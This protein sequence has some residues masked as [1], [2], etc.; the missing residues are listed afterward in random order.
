MRITSVRTAV[1]EA[2]YDWT[3][4][5]IEADSGLAGLGECFFAPGLTSII[6][7]LR[8]VL[9]GQDPRHVEPLVRRLQ[10]AASG[11]GSVSGIVYNAI[12]G[13]EAALLDLVGK[14]HGVPVWQL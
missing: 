3:F 13:M 6:R 4:V 10:R 7:D 11:A 12:T 9:V 8:E 1:I 5:R 2:N 14:A